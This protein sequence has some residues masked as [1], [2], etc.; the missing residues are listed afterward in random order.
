[1]PLIITPRHAEVPRVLMFMMRHVVLRVII[2]VID[3]DALR[4]IRCFRR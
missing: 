3:V 4:E 2:D 1:M